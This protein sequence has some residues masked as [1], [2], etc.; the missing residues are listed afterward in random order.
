MRL[1]AL[2][3]GAVDEARLLKPQIPA[4]GNY[5]IEIRDELEFELALGS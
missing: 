3:P 4:I 2:H 1:V 5:G